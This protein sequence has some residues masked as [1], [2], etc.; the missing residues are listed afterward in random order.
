MITLKFKD[1]ES[2]LRGRIGK[3]TGSRLGDITL[4]RG[5]G[6]KKGFYEL[7][8]ERVAIS[9]SPEVPSNPM[10]RG[11]YLEPIALARFEKIIGKKIDASLVLWMREDCEDIAVSPDGIIGKTEAVECKC[12]SSASHIEAWLNK[13][14]PD[15]YEYQVL[16]YFITNDKLKT[17][18]FVFFDPRIPNQDIFHLVVTRKELQEKIDEYLE[19]QI[20][21]LKTVEEI[22]NKL[23]F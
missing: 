13:K 1:K 4:K 14:I 23:S 9:D 8:A 6:Y 2:W 19:Y 16:Q 3:I 10:E 17:L 21:T 11:S 20:Q 18:Y 15:E 5:G 7:I 22:T 12:L